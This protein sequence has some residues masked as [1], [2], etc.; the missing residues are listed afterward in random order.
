M[1]LDITP[2]SDNELT[3]IFLNDESLYGMAR[4]A[5]SINELQ[6]IAKELFTFTDDQMSTFE[7]DFFDGVFDD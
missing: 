5:G 1:A 6:D 2:H 4:A 3:D 7:Q